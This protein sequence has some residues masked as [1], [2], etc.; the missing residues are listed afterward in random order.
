DPETERLKQ[1][2]SFLGQV[3]AGWS[4]VPEVAIPEEGAG[5]GS[6]V[7]VQ[8][9]EGG[10][11]ETYTLM[12]GALLDIDAG[13]VSLGSPTGRARLG[14]R[15]VAAVTVSTPP[16]TRRLRVLSGLTRRDRLEREVP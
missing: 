3:A 11:E 8:D 6:T 10:Q 14:P 9:V 13:Q 15:P 1:A 12:T 16:R 2:V 7:V 4:Q 5:F